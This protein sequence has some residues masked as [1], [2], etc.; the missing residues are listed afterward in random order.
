MHEQAMI[1]CDVKEANMMLKTKT[2]QRPEV[3][4][5]DFGVSKAMA[6]NLDGICG[7]PG[8]IPPET[9]DLQKWIPRGDVFSLGV[10]MLQMIA[11]KLPPQGKR[12]QWTPGG[13]FIE[14]CMTTMEIAHA[15][16]TRAVPMHLMSHHSPSLRLLVQAMLSK[17]ASGRP[18][19]ARALESAWFHE[20]NATTQFAQ[21][22]V[23]RRGHSPGGMANRGRHAFATV[24]IT[25]SFIA[26]FDNDDLTGNDSAQDRAMF[27]LR[28]VV[29]TANRP[30]APQTCAAPVNQNVVT[31]SRYTPVPTR[32]GATSVENPGPRSHV[33]RAQFASQE[34]SVR[35]KSVS[36]RVTIKPL[37]AGRIR[38]A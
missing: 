11:D 26:N 36:P 28:E 24:G 12:F 14:G 19:P 37:A 22:G 15:T 21:M 33:P 20:A 7:T 35:D 32:T 5:I 8:Y 30:Q 17:Q 18:T 38:R 10:V 6:K 16:R 23:E 1:H 29:Q 25:S 34:G 2:F 13:I 31:A 3:V 27:A 9:W 4:L